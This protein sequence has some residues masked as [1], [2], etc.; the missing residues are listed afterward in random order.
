MTKSLTSLLSVVAV[1]LCAAVG[2]PAALGA[3]ACQNEQLRAENN[4]TALPDC[5][6]YELVSPDS[7]HARVNREQRANAVA[8]GESLEYVTFDAPMNAQSAVPINNHIRARRDASH[9]WSGVSLSSPIVGPVAGYIDIRTM[10]VSEDLSATVDATKQPLTGGAPGGF[11]TFL[12]REDGSH[13]LLVAGE[14]SVPGGNSDFSHIYLQ[15]PEALLPSDPLAGGNI[16]SWTEARG[17]R[18]VGI[19]PD[20]TPAPDGAHL[21]GQIGAGLGSNGGGISADASRAVFTSEGRLYL[22]FDDAEQTVEASKSER[23]VEPDPNPGPALA[24]LNPLNPVPIAGITRAGSKVLFVAHSELTNDAYTGRSGGVAT[25]AGADLYSY[26]SVSG[27]LA[28][29]T[30]DHNPADTATGAN[31]K[32]VFAATADGSYVYFTATGDLA[33][34]AT[35]GHASLYVA[36]DGNVDFVADANSLFRV[37]TEPAPRFYMTPDG[38]HVVFGSSGSLTGYDNTDPLTGQPHVEVFYATIGAGVQ[39]VSCRVD[40]TRPTADTIVPEGTLGRMRVVSDDGRRVFFESS[41]AVVPQASSGLS[42]VFEYE[43][44]KVSPISRLDSSSSANLLAASASGDDVYFATFDALVPALTAGDEAVFDARVAGGFPVA[45][46]PGCSGDACHPPPSSAPVS[47]VLASR[48]LSA[49]QN[50]ASPAFTSPVTPT[51]RPLT[52][53]Q[54]FARALKACRSK[55]NKKKRVTCEKR[56]RR[57]YGRGR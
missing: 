27:H 54:K 34:G 46:R 51:P 6:A 47:G 50:I 52:R 57:A 16:Y 11:Q 20:G 2:A 21:V 7:N 17:F 44:G 30:V 33:P 45:S 53:A 24:V 35:P 9:G 49:V 3:D 10:A 18:L 56:A 5:R 4:S 23:T 48:S 55:H 41:D 39:C 1:L 37:S 19:L 12:G 36:H 42:Q 32:A 13:R 15:P 31:V 29:L 38:H 40:G 26:D 25:D 28:D 22:R 8:D 14:A 43:N